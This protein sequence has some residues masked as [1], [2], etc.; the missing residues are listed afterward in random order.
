MNKL[1]RTLFIFL[2]L[3]TTRQV[4]AQPQVSVNEPTDKVP[5][6]VNLS[7]T[8]PSADSALDNLYAIADYQ[9]YAPMQQ[10][11][12]LNHL[13]LQAEYAQQELSQLLSAISVNAEVD[14]LLPLTKS[15]DRA[16]QKVDN[17]FNGD[18]RLI[19]DI[20]RGSI[21]ANN[22][23]NLMASYQMLHENSEIVQI[24][25]RFANPKASGYR[26]LN[27]LIKL[28]QSQMI[29][30][31]QL[32]L[33]TIAAIKSGQDHQ[34]YQQIQNIENRA[35][36]EHRAL[37]ELEMQRITQI[38]QQSH[39]QYHKAWLVYKR[40]AVTASFQQAA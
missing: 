16:L 4:A 39:K 36:L 23:E 33:Q 35:N 12:D 2:I 29:V 3:L 22:V 8:T 17:K 18:A 1:F 38:R 25:N 27:V 15:Y 32:H 19:T 10:S 28:P 7:G 26:D 24:K 34:D 6:G 21:V 40:E 13:M 37:S 20:A 14:M 9:A 31:V 5:Y 30:E 11:A